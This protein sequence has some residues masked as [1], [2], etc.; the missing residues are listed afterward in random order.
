MRPR[1]R[2]LALTAHV[3]FSVGWLGSVVAYLVPAIVAL[4]SQDVERARACYLVMN[5]I[6]WFVIVP[7]GL[8]ALAS[9]LVQSLGTEWGVFRH[10]WILA[11][12][13]LTVIGVTILV[14]H[15]R[16]VTGVAGMSSETLSLA[17]S[18]EVKKHLVVHAVGGL[19][20]LLVATTLS[21]FK[22]WGKTGY[23]RR[24]TVTA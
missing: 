15:M 20:I 5:L 7:L 18:S 6:G 11:K 24:K 12:L 19:V 17:S 23:G 3:T 9:G 22:P 10:Y 21:V 2:K 1:L 13:V 16:S 14:A 4:T 8:G